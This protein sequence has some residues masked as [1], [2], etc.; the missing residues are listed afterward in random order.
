LTFTNSKGAIYY[1][2]PDHIVRRGSASYM[3]P[4]SPIGQPLATAY[5]GALSA[6]GEN[7]N[8]ENRP[9]ILNRP[10]RSVAELGYCF[11]GTP[12]KNIDF[13]NP[14]SGDS[15][16]LDIFSVG[17]TPDINGLIAGRVN[18]NTQQKPVIQALLAGSYKDEVNNY[19]YFFGANSLTAPSWVQPPITSTEAASIASVLTARTLGTNAT[20]GQGP[21]RNLA[22]LV[23]RYTGTLTTVAGDSTSVNYDGSLSF[24]GFSGDAG[25][26]SAFAA[27]DSF[28][29]YIDRLRASAVRAL[30]AGGQTRTWNLLIDVVAQTGNY[31]S[32]ATNFSQFAVQGEQRYWI[33]LA[34]DRYTGQVIDKQIE[35]IKE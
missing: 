14:E 13:I 8:L 18:L 25:L 19:P 11:S 21:L 1:S 9:I 4:T 12:W 5:T 22:E 34:I 32:T 15:A 6:A 26:T 29:P 35:A 27:H 30:S 23:G 33:H 31:P 3:Q 28:S 20:G 10:F 24:S 7:Q 17:D 2:D 16:L